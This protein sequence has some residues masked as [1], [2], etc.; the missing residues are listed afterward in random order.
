MSIT[1]LVTGGAGFIGSHLIDALLDRGDRVVCLD[2]FND[3]YDPA[4]KRANAAR[5][6]L[7]PGYRLVEGDIRDRTLLPDLM[8]RHW[9]TVVIHLAA[10]AGV[11]PSLIDPFK[12]QS[13]NLE[14]TLNL[15]EAAR[16]SGV[17]MFINASSSS[18]YGENT[19]APFEETDPLLTPASPYGASKLGAEA[20]VRVYARQYDMHAVS[21]RFF[22]VYGPRQRPDMAITKFTTR[23]LQGQPITI[24]GDGSARRDFT[25]VS[26]IVEGILASA[27][28][29]GSAYEAFNLGSGTT[30]TLQQ[31]I[32]ELELATGRFVHRLY[33]DEQAG[34]VPLTCSKIDKATRLLGYQPRVQLQAG[35]PEVVHALRGAEE[36]SRVSRVH[37]TQ[38]LTEGREFHAQA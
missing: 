38:L 14:G 2:D 35:L 24:Y 23:I 32:D 12:Y 5:H 21:L 17:E 26:D 16:Q 22:T 20:L 27:D 13:V 33:A 3:F 34:D 9:P 10:C 6:L 28:Y 36:A 7:R 25:F 18:V 30:V 37:V 19:K 11:R 29:R 1:C 8:R 15:L 4:L 31:L